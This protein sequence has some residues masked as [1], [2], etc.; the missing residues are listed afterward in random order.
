MQLTNSREHLEVARVL[1]GATHL[2][3]RGK[4]IVFVE[5]EP[6]VGS[7]VTDERLMRLITPQTNHWAI[8]PTREKRGVLDATERLR[9][10]ETAM[11]GQPV[12][13][14]VDA[15]RDQDP[16]PDYV[17]SWPVAM[18][19]NLLLEPAAILKVLGGFEAVTQPTHGGASPGQSSYCRGS[20]S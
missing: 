3:T 1:T 16:L 5:G 6:D 17:V 15:D 19:E 2:L 14:L 4:P 20:A 9:R 7:S 12:F 8:V 13:G 10:S 18:I 11:P